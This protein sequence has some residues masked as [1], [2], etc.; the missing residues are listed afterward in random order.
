MQGYGLWQYRSNTLWKVNG[1]D[2]PSEYLYSTDPATEI[3]VDEFIEQARQKVTENL[4]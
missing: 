1:Y 2:T 3:T 4:N